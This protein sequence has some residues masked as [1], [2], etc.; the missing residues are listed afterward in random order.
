MQ[1]GGQ[2]GHREVVGGVGRQV[3]R[4][5]THREGQAGQGEA[6]PCTHRGQGSLQ[7]EDLKLRNVMS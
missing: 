6:L 1:E 4:A 7:S 2:C 3:A 5:G